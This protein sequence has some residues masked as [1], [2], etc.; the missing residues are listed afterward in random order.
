MAGTG[1]PPANVRSLGEAINVATRPAHAK[2]N[3][4]ILLRLPLAIPPQSLTSSMYVTGLLHITPIYMAFESL[5]AQIHH[6]SVQ[7]EPGP[8]PVEAGPDLPAP[9]PAAPQWPFGDDD[10][11]ATEAF[12]RAHLLDETRALLQHMFI[13]GLLRSAALRADIQALT[14]WSDVVIDDQLQCAAATGSSGDFIEHIR[15]AVEEKPHVLLAYAWVL[16][17]ALFS[18]GRFIRET[19]ESIGDD[20]WGTVPDPVRPSLR[21]CLPRS[22]SSD[23]SPSRGGA[24][25]DPEPGDDEDEDA[26]SPLPA[27]DRTTPKLPLGFFRFA[28]PRDGDDLKELF[29]ARLLETDLQLTTLQRDDVVREAGHIFENM[30]KLVA[31]LDDMCPMPAGAAGDIPADDESPSASGSSSRRSS[32]A[33]A[34]ESFASALAAPRFGMM[35]LRDSVAVAKERTLRALRMREATT[36]PTDNDEGAGEEEAEDEQQGGDAEVLGL[37]VDA[38]GHGGADVEALDRV[39]KRHPV[40]FRA[41]HFEKRLPVPDRAEVVHRYTVTNDGDGLKVSA[42]E[43]EIVAERPPYQALQPLV[44]SFSFWVAIVVL[45]LAYSY[46]QCPSVAA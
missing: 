13:P 29:K 14:G 33:S 39:L 45:Y 11:P 19:L 15:L 7:K 18:G 38:T 32:S 46:L 26:V 35:R 40:A 41:V 24:D 17:M 10:S 2:L 5:W 20:F 44:T 1:K 27:S 3:R 43:A 12:T 30:I 28:T 25:E 6:S 4:L 22:S 23:L 9:W 34:L 16:Y 8:A 37:L 42:A 31:Q 36:K 21:L